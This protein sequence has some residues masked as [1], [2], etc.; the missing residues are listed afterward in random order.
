MGNL[1]VDKL[2]GPMIH[3]HKLSQIDVDSDLDMG[4]YGMILKDSNN[5]RWLITVNTDGA[6][7]TTKYGL[8]L[9]GNPIGLG[10]LFTYPA[11]QS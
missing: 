6:L 2:F 5:V 3:R 8:P 9:Q 10:L 1:T 11:D 7:V 4:D